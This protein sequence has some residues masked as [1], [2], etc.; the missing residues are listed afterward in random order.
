MS[1]RSYFLSD[2]VKSLSHVKTAE[3]YIQDK[4]YYVCREDTIGLQCTFYAVSFQLGSTLVVTPTLGTGIIFTLNNI[5]NMVH[6]N[7]FHD[8]IAHTR[9]WG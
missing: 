1:I 9:Q 2:T 5:L 8:K 4:R 7:N 6:I 3:L